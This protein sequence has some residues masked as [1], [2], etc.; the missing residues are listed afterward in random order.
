VGA[1]FGVCLSDV[2]AGFRA[3]LQL[4]AMIGL[5][6]RLLF[7]SMRDGLFPGAPGGCA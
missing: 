2:G 6:G 5:D 7:Q 1:G 3:Q 4:K